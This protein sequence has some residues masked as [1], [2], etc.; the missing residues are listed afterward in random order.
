[1]HGMCAAEPILI[2]LPIGHANVVCGRV[3]LPEIRGLSRQVVFHNICFSR[4][5]LS[6]YTPGMPHNYAKPVF[7]L[8][9]TG[10]SDAQ[11]G[12]VSFRA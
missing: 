12:S 7:T 11:T 2:Q 8:K 10:I 3:L 6:Y 4:Q 9:S 5:N 1:M